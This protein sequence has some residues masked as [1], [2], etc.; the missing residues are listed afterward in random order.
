MALFGSETALVQVCD[1]LNEMRRASS[2]LTRLI[3][4]QTD[5]A[6]GLHRARVHVLDAENNLQILMTLLVVNFHS[7]AN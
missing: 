2:Q 4:Q 3:E 5:V 6:E 7:I 1:T